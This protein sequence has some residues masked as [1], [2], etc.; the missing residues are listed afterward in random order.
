LP[1]IPFNFGPTRFRLLGSV[2]YLVSG[3]RS[4]SE[5]LRRQTQVNENGQ[6]ISDDGIEIL[7][8]TDVLAA[9][10]MRLFRKSSS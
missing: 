5:S 2:Q 10:C 7:L 8:D 9:G 4:F 6:V 1:T 3:C